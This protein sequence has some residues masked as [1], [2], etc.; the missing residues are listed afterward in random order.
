KMAMVGTSAIAVGTNQPGIGLVVHYGGSYGISAMLQHA[1]RAGR[2]SCPG[3]SLSLLTHDE[4]ASARRHAAEE[5]VD[6]SIE[7][8]ER[9]Q[10]Q[11][12]LSTPHC[13]QGVLEQFFNRRRAP[14]ITCGSCDN[15]VRHCMGLDPLPTT[16]GPITPGP[17]AMAMSPTLGEPVS[18]P[19]IPA[20][21]YPH[22]TPILSPTLTPTKIPASQALAASMLES[23]LSDPTRLLSSQASGGGS[24]LSSMLTMRSHSADEEPSP[25]LTIK[26]EICPDL[27]ADSAK[28]VSW[29]ILHIGGPGHEP[30]RWLLAA[31]NVGLHIRQTGCIVCWLQAG[32]AWEDH[33]THQCLHPNAVNRERLQSLSAAWRDRR[34]GGLPNGTHFH[35]GLPIRGFHRGGDIRG[36][37]NCRLQDLARDFLGYAWSN[38]FYSEAFF[39]LG[40]KADV[41]SETELGQDLQRQGLGKW[42][43]GARII[44][45]VPDEEVVDDILRRGYR[46]HQNLAYSSPEHRA[47]VWTLL[48]HV[49]PATFILSP[50]DELLLAFVPAKVEAHG[51]SI[52]I[53]PTKAWLAPVKAHLEQTG[54]FVRQWSVIAQKERPDIFLERRH[55][56][57]I[58][59]YQWQTTI[60]PAYPPAE[61]VSADVPPWPVY[62]FRQELAQAMA[63]AASRGRDLEALHLQGVVFVC[64]ANDGN[65]IAEQL[66]C[67]FY[68]PEQAWTTSW[69]LPRS[70][71]R[72]LVPGA[73]RGTLTAWQQRGGLLVMQ[74]G[75][76]QGLD[77]GQAC[78]VMH[79][80]IP[81]NLL[82]FAFELGHVGSSI[83]HS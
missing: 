50:G 73:D 58:V 17:P 37:G 54:L 47:A 62:I 59:F 32:P 55:I 52:W 83:E 60:P 75:Q 1:N 79:V 30:R 68:T 49:S 51:F 57:R 12:Y 8:N 40:V 65:R 16:S 25:Q 5:C 29:L 67:P 18:S 38:P 45:P 81:A 64:S 78:F 77:L 6:D 4:L 39:Q 80:G 31:T 42:A 72:L 82:D 24:Q 19:V 33:A 26:C 36:K 46:A 56:Q 7:A 11:Q 44:M 66:G 63:I 34:H 48:Q 2:G 23:I 20:F 14:G 76:Y 69:E 28:A 15:C 35:C 22:K 53:V 10:L 27:L 3:S 9:H 70:P 61:Q 13:R 41:T 71:R 21:S 74:S 43:F